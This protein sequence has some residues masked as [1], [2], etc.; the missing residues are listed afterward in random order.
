MFPCTRTHYLH[1]HFLYCSGAFSLYVM[2]LC[3][4]LY[5]TYH[6]LHI[7]GCDDWWGIKEVM[8]HSDDFCK[9]QCWYVSHT[10]CLVTLYLSKDKK[11]KFLSSNLL[12]GFCWHNLRT[13]W[14]LNAD[15]W[16][17]EEEARGKWTTAKSTKVCSRY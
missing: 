4:A 14:M 1:L 13:F 16:G 7:V 10:P 8:H 11:V 3:C 12:L 15:S 9:I 17:T 5:S 2:L 6:V